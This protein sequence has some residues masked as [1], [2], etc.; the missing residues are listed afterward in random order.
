MAIT[1]KKKTTRKKGANVDENIKKQE[2]L[3][4]TTGNVK[5]CSYYGENSMENLQKIKNKIII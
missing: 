3:C 5:W 4:I 2:S 1:I